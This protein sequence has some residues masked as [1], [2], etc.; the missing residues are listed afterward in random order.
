MTDEIRKQIDDLEN[1]SE[2]V[3]LSE[4]VQ[5]CKDVA[6]TMRT[7]LAENTVLREG[8]DDF[9]SQVADCAS[10]HTVCFQ[11]TSLAE[12]VQKNLAAVQ[13]EQTVTSNDLCPRCARPR[14]PSDLCSS[15]FHSMGSADG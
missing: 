10:E 2:N 3:Y 11:I 7:M 1:W 12:V 15:D 9:V 6:A 5:F 8:V 14:G 13:A 4:T